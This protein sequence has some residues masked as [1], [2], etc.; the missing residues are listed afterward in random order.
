MIHK[1]V[2]SY[3]GDNVDVID[4]L[5]GINYKLTEEQ[6]QLL[7]N[8]ICEHKQWPTYSVVYS[9]RK[10]KLI[11]G[12]CCPDEKTVKIYKNFRNVHTLIHEIT[13]HISMDHNMLFKKTQLSLI[14]LFKTKFKK[15]MED[16]NV[17]AKC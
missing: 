9:N 11:A 5:N 6:A 4:E 13:H 16:K 15:I 14:K 1:K 12:T 8:L 2:H 17:R 10:T 7:I 3:V